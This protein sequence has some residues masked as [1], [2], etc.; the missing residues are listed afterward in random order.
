MPKYK[1][2][3]IDSTGKTI[4]GQIEAMT[5]NQAVQILNNR[6]LVPLKCDELG[7]LERDIDITI[8]KKVKTRD[9]CVFCRQFVSILEA[10]VNVLNALEMLY[11]QTENKYLRAAVKDLIQEVEKGEPLSTALANHKDVFPS[12]LIN[13]VASGEATGSMDKAFERMALSLE[14]DDRINQSVKKAMTYPI[15][16]SIVA[17]GVIIL[18]MSFVV[19]QF[20]DMFAQLDTELPAI[21]RSLIAISGFITG[22]WYIM[23]AVLAALI[24]GIVIFKKQDSGKRFFDKLK[25]KFPV[26]GKVVIKAA[27]ARYSRTMS[28]LMSAG[29]PLMEALKVTAKIMG[30]VH[31][32]DALNMA[33]DKVSKGQE[34]SKPLEE[35]KLFPPMVYHMTKIGEDTGSVESMYD[36]VAEYYEEEVEIAVSQAVAFLEPCM[37]IIL[38]IIIGYVLLGILIPMFSMYGAIG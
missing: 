32:E 17:F 2:K 25:L 7:L 33:R 5:R 18:L 12:L 13:M 10:G 21:T 28:S 31:F 19:P 16:V 11:D 38:G 29:I 3:A 26:V 14:K 27:C 1:Y 6:S 36:K 15:I 20:V 23:V 35:S 37:I 34:L 8:G 30:N 24:A 4:K 22:R 9:L